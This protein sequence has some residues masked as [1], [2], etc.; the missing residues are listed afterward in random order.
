MKQNLPTMKKIIMFFFASCFS[1]NLVAQ[2]KI[3]FDTLNID[4]LNLYND[5][6]IKL[7]KTGMIMT[8]G[9]GIVAGTSGLLLINFAY[10]HIFDVD[11]TRGNIYAGIM[12]CGLAS[13]VI[14]IPLWITGGN[15]K[16]RADI[17]LKKFSVLPDNTRVVGIGLTVRF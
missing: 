10:G 3:S 17:A 8:I 2:Q 15:R 9:G 11:Q 13:T 7:N 1:L 5:N 12:F 6:A 4:Q 16:S 14:G